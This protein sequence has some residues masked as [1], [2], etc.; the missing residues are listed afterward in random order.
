MKSVDLI[1]T[2]DADKD[3]GL[4]HEHPH[5]RWARREDDRIDH[6]PRPFAA[7][8]AGPGEFDPHKD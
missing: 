5:L 7:A 4:T 6:T 3:Q 8:M 2:N 1:Q